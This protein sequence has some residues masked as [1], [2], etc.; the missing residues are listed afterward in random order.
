MAEVDLVEFA[1]S[2]SAASMPPSAGPG[3]ETKAK[4][5]ADMR[6]KSRVS[7]LAVAGGLAVGIAATA[8]AAPVPLQALSLAAQGLGFA[9]N[10]IAQMVGFGV[11]VTTS[12]ATRAVLV[13]R[14]KSYMERVN[15]EYFGP[16]GLKAMIVKDAELVAMLKCPH[17]VPDMV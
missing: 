11:G 7:T 10:G 1:I 12:V 16:R 2:T 5:E 15:K 13:A 3:V 8:Q 17:Q 4:Q 6:T 9:P 14:T